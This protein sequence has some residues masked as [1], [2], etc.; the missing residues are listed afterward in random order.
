LA[1]RAAAMTHEAMKDFE[2]QQV[3]KLD[4]PGE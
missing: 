3:R 4:D 1:E 2:R